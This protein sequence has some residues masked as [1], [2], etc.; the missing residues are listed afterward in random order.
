MQILLTI[1]YCAYLV[2]YSFQI[3]FPGWVGG[4]GWLGVGGWGWVAGLFENKA[5]SVCSAELKLE[6]D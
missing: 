1:L 5:N 3:N 2:S 4:W 6:L